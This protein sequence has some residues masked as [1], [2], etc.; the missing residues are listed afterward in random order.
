MRDIIWLIIVLLII[1]WLIGYFAFPDLGSIIHI[2]I[3]LAVI[4]LL[5]RLLTG[6]RL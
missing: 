2:L 6:R 5:Y 3:V 4:L 1:G